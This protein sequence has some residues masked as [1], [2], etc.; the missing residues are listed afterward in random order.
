MTIV[1]AG[2]P[3]YTAGG[4]AAVTLRHRSAL[5]GF[6]LLGPLSLTDGRDVVALQ[7]SKPTTL[8]AA[9]LL[10]PNSTVST[11]Y[12]L[13]A[14]WGTDQAATS[15]A[16]LHTCMMRLR[17]TFAN[18]SIVH[19]KIEALPGGYRI[20]ADAETLDLIKFRQLLKA[21]DT[22][23]GQEVELGILRYALSLWQGP[24]LGNVSSAVLHDSEVPRID[25]ERLGAV[26]RV[27]DIEIGIGRCREVLSELWPTARSYP[28]RERF[29]EQLIE[30]LYRTG[31]QA[32]ALAEYHRVKCFLR[33]ELAVGPGPGLQRLELDILRGNDLGPVA[34]PRSAAGRAGIAGY[35]P[36]PTPSPVR[37]V[38]EWP[39]G[40][41]AFVGRQSQLASVCAR[42]DGRASDPTIVVLSGAPGIGKTALALQAARLSTGAF[43]GGG[44]V[45]PMSHPDG[46]ARGHDQILAELSRTVP[47]DRRTMLVLDD[48][49]SA[50]HVRPVLARVAGAA[51]IT[52]RMSLGGVIA[53]NGGRVH[54]LDRLEEQESEALL[55]SVLGP[56]RVAAEPA[57][58]RGLCAACGHFPLALKIIATRLLTR[59]RLRIADCVDW[60]HG[61]DLARW[62]LGDAPQLSIPKVFGEALI[63]LGP[64]AAEAFVK[65]GGGARHP[66]SVVDCA[67]LLGLTPAAAEDALELL[68]D[69][70]LMDE[71]PPGLYHMPDLLRTV[72][73]GLARR[74]RTPDPTVTAAG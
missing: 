72:A 70:S 74:S 21:A 34:A 19:T 26:E 62:S 20:A 40:V 11:D 69:A 54:R 51:V 46:S 1:Q 24:L 13:R 8:L 61:A 52:S 15:K 65:I 67:T 4:S 28:G 25:E 14:V 60:L 33:E 57:A 42:L 59:P 64:T 6:R 66:V 43:P 3:E 22:E 10:H 2:E 50:D 9:L 36:E 63:R 48:A 44:F 56:E 32:E 23:P 35:R 53:T 71:G 37:P 39:G 29:S 31:R 47:Q 18:H 55:R 49:H 16:A 5:T 27:F 30:A 7:P 41:T 73:R 58:V 38:D 68:T 45:V 17:R 12:L